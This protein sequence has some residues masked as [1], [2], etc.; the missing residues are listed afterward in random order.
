MTGNNVGRK[1]WLKQHNHAGTS[2]LVV[3]HHH[4][5]HMI[6]YAGGKG[7]LSKTCSRERS[8]AARANWRGCF[9]KKIHVTEKLIPG[10][11]N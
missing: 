5:L 1:Q 2:I 4:V 8:N 10:V 11:K 3:S 7:R 6:D 9:N